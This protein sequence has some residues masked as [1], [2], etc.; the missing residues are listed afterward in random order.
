MRRHVNTWCCRLG[1]CLLLGGHAAASEDSPV[2]ITGEWP[3]YTA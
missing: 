1:L 2:L 3:P